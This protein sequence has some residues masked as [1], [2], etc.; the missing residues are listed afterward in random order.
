VSALV[1]RRYRLEDAD[2]AYQALARGEITGR[3]IITMGP[4]QS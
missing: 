3:A 1:T 2:E 4:A